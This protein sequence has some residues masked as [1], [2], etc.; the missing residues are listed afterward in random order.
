MRS[1]SREIDRKKYEISKMEGILASASPEFPDCEPPTAKLPGKM[2]RTVSTRR[3][4]RE[5]GDMYTES[6]EKNNQNPS[7]EDD[8]MQSNAANPAKIDWVAMRRTTE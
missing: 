2:C 8:S 4:P 3:N 6:G 5:P 7:G 1:D